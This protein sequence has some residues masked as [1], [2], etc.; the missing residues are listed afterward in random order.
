MPYAG[1]LTVALAGIEETLHGADDATAYLLVLLLA[2]IPWIEI[3]L[4]IPPAIALGLD[5]FLVTLTAFAGNAATLYAA[6]LLHARLSIWWQARQEETK[7]KRSERARHLWDAYGLGPLAIASPLVTGSHL[8]A[9]LA[10]LFGSKRS[11][12]TFWMTTS[13]AAWSLLLTAATLAGMEV[14]PL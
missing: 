13:L 5:P 7:S 4:V 2:A 6:I 10:L 1:S 12:V 11:H 14:I 8:A 9:L 3:L